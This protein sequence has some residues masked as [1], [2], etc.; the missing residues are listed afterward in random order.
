MT[1][2]L[3]C[4]ASVTLRYLLYTAD[5]GKYQALW[6]QWIKDGMSIYA[7][8]LWASEVASGISKSFYFGQINQKQAAELHT[9]AQELPIQLMLAT[10]QIMDKALAWTIKLKRKNAYDCFLSL[11]HI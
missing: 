4:D 2:S 11:I 6:D 7:P 8:A 9:S 5:Q 10:P 3:V 1:T